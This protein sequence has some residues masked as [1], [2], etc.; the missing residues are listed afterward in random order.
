MGQ[1]GQKSGGLLEFRR[2]DGLAVVGVDRRPELVGGQGGQLL[3]DEVA[4][5][6]VVAAPLLGE[7]VAGLGL[8]GSI[9]FHVDLQFLGTVGELA[10]APVGAVPL[11]GET[12][13]Q[14]GLGLLVAPPNHG[15]DVVVKPTFL[16]TIVFFS[17]SRCLALGIKGVSLRSTI[18]TLSEDLH[19]NE[20]I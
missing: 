19:S 16:E 14:R 7:D 8:V 4:A 10:L 9:A 5:L 13:A 15:F 1:D 2:V 18:S 3:V 12:F 20:I 11:L 6:A 17:L